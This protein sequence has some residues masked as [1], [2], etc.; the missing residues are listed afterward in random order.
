MKNIK[1]NL[2]AGAVVAPVILASDKT[3]LTKFQGDKSAWPVY[4]SIGNISKEKR[5]QLSAH[6]T[7]LLGYLPVTKLEC[8]QEDTRSL[9]GYRLFEVFT[10]PHIV[11]SDSGPDFG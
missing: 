11:R 5:R 10:V 1:G 8:F 2:L 6:A 3:Q 7:V 9:A 4:L